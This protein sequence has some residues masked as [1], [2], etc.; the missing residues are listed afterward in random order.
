MFAKSQHSYRHAGARDVLQ[1]EP[2]RLPVSRGDQHPGQSFSAS[3][4]YVGQHVGVHVTVLAHLRLGEDGKPHVA[5]RLD[6]GPNHLRTTG[7][8]VG[9]HRRLRLTRHLRA[10]C[11]QLGGLG[12][13]PAAQRV[14][15]WPVRRGG[16]ATQDG[17]QPH[18]EVG[19][20]PDQQYPFG[21]RLHVHVRGS[22]GGRIP[23]GFVDHGH[24]CLTHRN[25]VTALPACRALVSYLVIGR[26]TD[27][28]SAEVS[29]P[30]PTRRNSGSA[31]PT[32][33]ICSA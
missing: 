28:G 25:S 2:E 8:D 16:P 20:I 6:P 11:G 31:S 12:Q 29:A 15:P 24:G 13:Q 5:Q 27:I 19:R 17:S 22:G 9:E 1:R 3:Q 10:P 32:S 7:G 23:D 30:N 33:A 14:E 4:R 21:R 26:C 18:V